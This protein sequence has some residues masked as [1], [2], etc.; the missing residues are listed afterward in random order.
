M[1][2]PTR[3]LLCAAMVSVI[4]VSAVA[5]GEG[6]SG[7]FGHG[8]AV[9]PSSHSSEA[10]KNSNGRFAADRDHGRD[11]A[12]DRMHALGAKHGK[13]THKRPDHEGTRSEEARER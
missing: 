9:G 11:R 7:G 3:L 2:R 6:G 8:D 10:V 12:H 13:A 4:S 1:H 5:R